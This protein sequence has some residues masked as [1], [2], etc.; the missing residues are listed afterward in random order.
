MPYLLYA[1]LAVVLN[2]EAPQAGLALLP[3]IPEY[4]IEVKHI[5]A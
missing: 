1:L 3:F 5:A 2:L 4:T